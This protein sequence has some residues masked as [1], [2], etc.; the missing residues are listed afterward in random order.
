MTLRSRFS[1]GARCAATLL[2]LAPGLRAGAQAPTWPD[3]ANRIGPYSGVVT[4]E[5]AQSMSDAGFNLTVQSAYDPTVLKAMGDAGIKHI[6]I[7]LWSYI[8][9]QCKAQFDREAASGAPRHCELAPDQ[10]QTILAQAAARLDKIKDDPTVAAYWVLDDYPWGDIS[11]TLNALHALVTKVNQATHAHKA[12]IC[13]VGGSLDHRNAT[14]PAIVPDRAYIELSLRNVTPAA[15]DVIAPYFYGAATQNDPTWI[16]WSMGNLM[17]WFMQQ[18]RAKG[19][20]SPALLPVT[21]AFYA[22]KR[23]GTT[24][25]VQPRP[26]DMAAQARTYCANGAIALMF[27]T[28]AASDAEHAYTNDESLRDGVHQAAAACQGPALSLPDLP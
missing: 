8:Y 5:D 3:L 19:F 7:Q 20:A 28:W 2:I 11:S 18:L 6:D 10:Q 27:F 16:D 1:A 13:G 21:H 24:Y 22:G 12:V 17:P 4:L 9:A 14:N 25:Y 23:G 15:C 26:Q